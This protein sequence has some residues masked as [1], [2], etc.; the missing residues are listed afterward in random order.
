MSGSHGA[1]AKAGTQVLEAA[2]QQTHEQEPARLLQLL[3]QH[4]IGTGR[5][6]R[7]G[8]GQRRTGELSYAGIGNTR[9]CLRGHEPR[10]ASPATGCLG[11]VSHPFAAAPATRRGD[12]V[13]LIRTVS[14]NPQPARRCAG[15]GSPSPPSWHMPGDRPQWPQHRRCQLH[16]AARAGRKGGLDAATDRRNPAVRP[17]GGTHR[18]AQGDP[19]THLP[20]RKS[21]LRGTA[22]GRHLRAGTP[23]RWRTQSRCNCSCGWSPAQELWLSLSADAPSPRAGRPPFMWHPI[24][25][26]RGQRHRPGLPP[27]PWP[28][29][30]LLQQMQQQFANRPGTSCLR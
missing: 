13:M 12:V 18:P 5:R 4:C 1:S 26:A 3:H 8:P 27:A 30:L 29:E 20:R 2:L 28:D 22:G 10:A 7:R 24:G 17:G 23:A 16:R 21:H 15:S 11:S 6:R 9:I 25:R 14:A 19:G